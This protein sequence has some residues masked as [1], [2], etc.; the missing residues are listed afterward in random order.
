MLP[1]SNLFEI[2]FA[3]YP[4]AAKSMNGK[5]RMPL[6]LS[7]ES[8]PDLYDRVMMSL[9]RAAPRALL[10]RDVQSQLYTFAAAGIG[11]K[12]SLDAVFGLLRADPSVLN[13]YTRDE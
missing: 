8:C 13:I 7:I 12:A 4:D 10:A 11:G 9:V 2:I 1:S 3:A 6:H 5:G